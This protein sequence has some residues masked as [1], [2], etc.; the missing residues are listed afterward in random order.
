MRLGPRWVRAATVSHGHQR[1]RT[2]TNGSDKPQ[3][4]APTAR[5]AGMMQAGDSDYGPEGRG[6][7]SPR[8]PP[9]P[10]ISRRLERR[11]Q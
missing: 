9:T 10:Q 8:L 6:V 4:A 1:A 11:S 7:E 3:V 2:V 5:A